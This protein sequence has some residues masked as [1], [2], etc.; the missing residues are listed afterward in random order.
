MQ[1]RQGGGGPEEGRA[2]GRPT[3]TA[4]RMA[5]PPAKGIGPTAAARAPCAAPAPPP[6]AP[7]AKDQPALRPSADGP[8]GAH[9]TAGTRARPVSDS[10]AAQS[11][12]AP[13]S[14]AEPVAY[15]DDVRK[16]YNVGG[17]EVR[18]LAGVSVSF[19]AG[20]FWAIMGPSGSGKS[21]MLNLLGCLDRPTSGRYLLEGQDVAD[22]TTTRSASIRLRHLG[23][24]FQS[25]NLIPQLTVRENI[26]LPLFYLA[27]RHTTAEPAREELAGRVGSGGTPGAPPDRALRRPAAARGDRAR[28]G[29]RPRHPPGR[30]ADRQPRLRATGVQIM[31]LLAD[32]NR[33]GKTMIVVTHEADIAR[34]AGHRLHMR[35]G[36]VDVSRR[37]R[38]A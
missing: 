22:W 6:A 14:T 26:E 35:D 1:E 9:A 5:V 11:K 36:R 20:S 32:L 13:S 33:Q 4:R 10:H 2:G 15:L 27:G 21:T 12:L 7:P 8:G 24:I 29:Q 19:A 28:P 25:F 37:T 34:Y 31:D 16:I 3:A 18:A 17:T 38:P 23:F 30:R